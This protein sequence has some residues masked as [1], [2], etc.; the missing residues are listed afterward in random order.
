MARKA[1]APW[2]SGSEKTKEYALRKEWVTSKE[3]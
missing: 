2:N 1:A 3:G